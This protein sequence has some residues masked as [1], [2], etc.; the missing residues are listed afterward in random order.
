MKLREPG[1]L[2]GLG[3]VALILAALQVLAF[4]RFLD[5]VDDDPLGV[6]LYIVAIAAFVVIAGV[7]FAQA[8]DGV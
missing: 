6:A 5:R 2:R 8:R 3:T 1:F 7:F 4:C